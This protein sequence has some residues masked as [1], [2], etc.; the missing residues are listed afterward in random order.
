MNVAGLHRF[1]LDQGFL[2]D[3]LLKNFDKPHELYRRVVPD[4]VDPVGHIRDGLHGLQDGC[5]NA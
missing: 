5:D 2:A 3:R 4:I 1:E